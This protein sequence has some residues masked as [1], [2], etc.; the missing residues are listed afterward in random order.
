M[1]GRGFKKYLKKTKKKRQMKTQEKALHGTVYKRIQIK[2]LKCKS[3]LESIVSGRSPPPDTYK[4]TSLQLF[5]NQ[6]TS[7]L[8]K[9]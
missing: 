9:M 1:R 8:M 6:F 5:K 4:H 7:T 3:Y 2:G